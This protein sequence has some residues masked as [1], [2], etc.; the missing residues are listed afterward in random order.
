[1]DSLIH[2]TILRGSENTSMADTLIALF[3][4]TLALLACAFLLRSLWRSIPGLSELSLK[5]PSYSLES[6]QLALLRGRL[7]KAIRAIDGNESPMRVRWYLRRSL[8]LFIK[9][10]SPSFLDTLDVYQGAW[11]NTAIAALRKFQSPSVGLSRLDRL[12][13]SQLHTLRALL[14]SELA[15][16][17]IEN[18]RG[19]DGKELPSWAKEE[20]S[21][22]TKLLHERLFKN[23]SEIV[24]A[25]EEFGNN[26]GSLKNSQGSA[27]GDTFLQ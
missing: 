17:E 5:M 10:S 6:L 18:K 3:L 9:S 11:L 19:K 22:K 1:M 8:P 13:R 21:K 23:R 7:Q 4:G 12:L 26:L 16:R 25:F 14:D 20:Q 2:H 15:W 27:S 24:L